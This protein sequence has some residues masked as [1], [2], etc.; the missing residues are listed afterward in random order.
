MRAGTR[1][2][3]IVVA[4]FALPFDRSWLL[5][6]ALF[7][8]LLLGLFPFTI[9][10]FSRVLTSEHPVGDAVGALVMTL[11][12]LIVTFASVFFLLAHH[13]PG[14]MNGLSTRVDAMYFETTVLSTVGFGDI[15][16]ASQWARGLVTINMLL[17]LVY[18]GTTLR[19]MSWAVQHRVADSMREQP[20]TPGG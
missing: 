20:I 8:L 16:A 14:S 1:A 18:I 4:Y 3:A 5:T 11:V 15:T 2:A 6:A 12:I 13:S 19:L 7:G 10:R 9:R 17:D